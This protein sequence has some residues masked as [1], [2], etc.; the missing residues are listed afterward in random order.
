[1]KIGFGFD[2]SRVKIENFE[3]SG[4]GLIH[5]NFGVDFGEFGFF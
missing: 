1:V 4:L 2:L 5:S 3:F